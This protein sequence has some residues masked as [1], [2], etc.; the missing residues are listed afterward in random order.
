VTRPGGT[1]A[2]KSEAGEKG[3]L[4]LRRWGNTVEGKEHKPAPL[5]APGFIPLNHPLGC[6]EILHDHRTR[7][8]T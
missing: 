3:S 7:E 2:L 8:S 6:C 4:S 1:G 5:R